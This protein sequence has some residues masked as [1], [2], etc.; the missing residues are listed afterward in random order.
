MSYRNSFVYMNF[1][2]FVTLVT[3]VENIRSCYRCYSK[4]KCSWVADILL[5]MYQAFQDYE[6]GKANQIFL[7][8]QACMK[9][10]MKIRGSNKYD[11]PH[12][13][14]EMLERQGRLPLPLGC[15]VSLVHEVM[16][17]INK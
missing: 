11:T 5:Y 9:E 3:V 10:V 2:Y 4:F 8:L 17:Q 14:K 7:T 12:I 16:A 6:V 15:E 1:W 13:R